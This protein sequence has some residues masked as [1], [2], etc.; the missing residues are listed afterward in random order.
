MRSHTPCFSRP[1]GPYAGRASSTVSA[2]SS[3]RRSSEPSTA[4]SSALASSCVHCGRPSRRPHPRSVWASLSTPTSSSR[5]LASSHSAITSGSRC[6]PPHFGALWLICVRAPERSPIAMHSRTASRTVSRSPRMWLAYRPP[7]RVTTSASATTSSVSPKHPGGYTSP[8]DIPNAPAEDVTIRGLEIRGDLTF[9]VELLGPRRPPLVA[10]HRQAH[11]AVAEEGHDVHADAGTIEDVE[12]LGERR[13]RVRD[14]VVVV[15]ELALGERACA[16]GDRRRRDPAVARDV[17]GH[18]LTHDVLGGGVLQEPDVAVRV[19]VDEAGRDVP[20]GGLD[21]HARLGAVERADPN[22]TPILDPHVVASR[23]RPGPVEQPTAA[24]QDVEHQSASRQA[25][26][27]HP[28]RRSSARRA[29]WVSVRVRPS[30]QHEGASAP[31]RNSAPHR[32]QRFGAHA[33]AVSVTGTGT[34]SRAM[35]EA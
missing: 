11:R 7:W 20:V 1:T 8:V 10:E 18:A 21:H 30:H 22:H 15:G 2:I 23:R 24:D 12:V 9:G 32:A 33:A 4:T 29:R 19:D 35:T 5:A 26:H 14:G 31:H 27:R 28:S 16:L 25:R 13:P 17:G 3:R 6:V 34:V